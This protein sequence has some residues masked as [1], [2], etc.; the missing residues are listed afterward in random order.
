MRSLLAALLSTVILLGLGARLG[1]QE[2]ARALIV[3]AVA[4]VGGE[5][6][7]SRQGAMETKMKGTIPVG[8][9]NFPFTA[10]VVTQQL[11]GGDSQ[12]KFTLD[13]EILTQK[14]NITQ[15]VAGGKGWKTLDGQLSDLT[16][17]EVQEMRRSAYVD[18]VTGL[19][20]LLKDKA[21]TLT[22]L[23]EGKVND[24]PVLGVKV[25]REG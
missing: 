6:K 10:T 9:D 3:K 17:A 24:Q 15:T 5:E 7:L 14:H 25:A 16:D 8:G 2:D 19:V 4:A 12:A 23:G 13:V 11:P 18:Q 22:A 20:D 1:A 21:F